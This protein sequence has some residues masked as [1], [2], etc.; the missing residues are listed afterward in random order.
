MKKFWVKVEALFL[1]LGFLALCLHV[2]YK[3]YIGEG[4]HQYSNFFG[5]KF[6]YLGIAV[7]ILAIPF[8]F[9]LGR[10]IEWIANRH[11]R[12]LLKKYNRDPNK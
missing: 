6:N 11:E 9:V 2:A 7:L 12:A 10:V 3:I 8:V 1:L 5:L 4:T